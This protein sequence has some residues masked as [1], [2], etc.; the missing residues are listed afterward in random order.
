MGRVV[1]IVDVVLDFME[2]DFV[3]GR[4]FKVTVI[5]GDLCARRQFVADPRTQLPSKAALGAVET[6]DA[7][8]GVSIGILIL[9]F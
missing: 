3:Q 7:G 5:E 1:V 8:T 9:T 6:E 4:P 2:L